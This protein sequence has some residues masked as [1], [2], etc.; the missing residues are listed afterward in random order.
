MNAN[1]VT[2][3]ELHAYADGQLPDA[4]RADVDA[5]LAQRPAELERVQAWREQNA[6]L[7]TLFDPV[8]AEPVPLRLHPRARQQWP[9]MRTIA[10][11][12][13][14]AIVG[15]SIGWIARGQRD[16]SAPQQYAQA[17][18]SLPHQAALAHAI[19][20]PE[21]RHPVEV[22]ADQQAHLVQ[23]LSKRLGTALRPPV[24]VKQGFELVGG[25]LLPGE[26]GPVAQFMYSDASGQRLTLYVTREQG[27]NRDTGFR[28]AQEGTV[29]VFYWIDG[30]FGYA[31]SGGLPKAELATVAGTVYDQLET[32]K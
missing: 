5:W 25:R 20:T 4:R 16:A 11:A 12:L 9:P 6:A 30:R 19:Y 1:P 31:L 24:L 17:A 15:A 10:A 13:L 21:V 28:F 29:N 2:D 3:A 18:R 32:L 27:K 23:W 26:G 14:L 8:L 22:G 7:R